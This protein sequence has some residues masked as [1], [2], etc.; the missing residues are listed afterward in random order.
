MKKITF[1][2]IAL[3]SISFFAQGKE[4]KEKVRAYKIAYLTEKLDLS[5][6]EAEKFWPIYN[7][8]SKNRRENYKA[9]KKKIKAKIDEKGGPE[10]LSNKEAEIILAEITVL[11]DNQHQNKLKFRDKLKSILSAKKV[12]QFELAQAEFNK[13]ND[14]TTKRTKKM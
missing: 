8:Y 7:E 14:E 2:A 11:R 1:I 3:F 10:N 13:K 12:L 6:E 4:G 5:S 9:K